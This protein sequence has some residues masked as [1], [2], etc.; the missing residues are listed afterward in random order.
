MID[1]ANSEITWTGFQPGNSI[2]GRV[3]FS[4]GY[5]DTSDSNKDITGGK[6]TIDMSSIDV[7]DDKLDAD[8]KHKLV[9][10]LGSEDF[11]DSAIHPLAVFSIKEVNAIGDRADSSNSDGTI[12]PTHEVVGEL[13]LKGIKHTVST[14]VNLQISEKKI[15]VQTMLTLDRTQWGMDHLID[16]SNGKNRVLPDMEI[17]LKVVAEASEQGMRAGL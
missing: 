17:T 1:V 4:D 3:F 10:H 16:R 2:S 11:F 5:V 12:Q 15:M 9:A 13:S 6:L 14:L 8:N 7:M